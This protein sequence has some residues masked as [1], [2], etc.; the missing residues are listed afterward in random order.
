M[1]ASP[2]PSF[3][4]GFREVLPPIITHNNPQYHRASTS[5]GGRFNPQPSP[6]VPVTSDIYA[7][8]AL[9]PNVMHE[10]QTH[11][12]NQHP[13]PSLSATYNCPRMFKL[14]PV[15]DANIANWKNQPQQYVN[16]S[17][18]ILD[19]RSQLDEL[20]D[21][22]LSQGSQMPS[23]VP[24]RMCEDDN[25][26]PGASDTESNIKV[27]TGSTRLHMAAFQ[28]RQLAEYYH[29]Q[30]V[31]TI[32]LK[33]MKHE[34]GSIPS[35][36]YPQ[37]LVN[38][39]HG[40]GI[41]ALTNIPTPGVRKARIHRCSIANCGKTYMKRSHL[42]THL[43]THTGEKP[44]VCTHESC[45]KR[46]SRSDELTR[47]TRKHTGAKPFQCDICHRGFSRSDHLTT[48]IRTHT[49]ERPFACKYKM[50]GR[51]FAR[52][53]ELNRHSKIH[54]RKPVA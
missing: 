4:T 45:G 13:M 52:S 15:S 24:T 42:E 31:P 37:E 20:A 46:F 49:G 53:D 27:P 19:Q 39:T 17:G 33:K 21:I 3:T 47:H 44:F 23:G 10:G 36:S 51:K 40:P 9:G 8:S 2:P 5:H 22:A 43:R 28:D 26:S 7:S 25:E 50:C 38:L 18:L 54:D 41:S 48:H 14:V 11:Y 12:G 34:S 1:Q 35:S 6:L 16:F 32:P 30:K 29:D